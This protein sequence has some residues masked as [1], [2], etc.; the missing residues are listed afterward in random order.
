ML[1]DDNKERFA[2]GVEFA[3]VRLRSSDQLP[4]SRIDLFISMFS[5]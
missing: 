1:S 2:K 3:K 4:L 5:V